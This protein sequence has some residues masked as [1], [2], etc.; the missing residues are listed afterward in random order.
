MRKP[1]RPSSLSVLLAATVGVGAAGTGVARAQTGD[2]DATALRIE[3][4]ASPAPTIDQVVN[5]VIRRESDLLRNL[6][7]RQPLVETYIQTLTNDPDLGAV[8]KQDHYF[9]GK[10]DM[11]RGVGSRSLI[12]A[13]GLGKKVA[14]F[15]SE[16]YQFTFL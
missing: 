5:V 3:V 6:L 16:I 4:R 15:F 11:S 12:P 14:G 1:A 13:P 10:L 2:G 9:L 7:I 8:P